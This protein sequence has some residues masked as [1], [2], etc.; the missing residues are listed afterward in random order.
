M[1]PPTGRAAY[2]P[3]LDGPLV[4]DFSQF[5][6]GLLCALKLADGR[7]GDQDRTPRRSDL[8]RSLYISDTEIGG[9]NSLFHAINRTWCFTADLCDEGDRAMLRQL[10]ARADVVMQNFRPGVI[11]RQGFAM[12]IS[13]VSSI[14][15]CPTLAIRN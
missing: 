2:D 3:S 12:T 10:V 6:S 15:E 1:T 8:C 4:I 9:T 5:L 11:E 7:A 14:E 13:A